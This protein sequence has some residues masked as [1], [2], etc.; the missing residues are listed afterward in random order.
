MKNYKKLNGVLS[1]CF[2]SLCLPGLPALAATLPLAA[3]TGTAMAASVDKAVVKREIDHLLQTLITSK[4]EFNRN[5]S[6]YNGA[7]A[8]SHLIKKYDYFM[9]RGEISNAESFIE[10]AASKSSLSGQAYLVKCGEAKPLE[11]AAWLKQELARYRTA[12]K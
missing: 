9:L 3:T 7:D 5:G 1:C 11:S 8:K 4:C 10:L 12:A 2:I 6:W